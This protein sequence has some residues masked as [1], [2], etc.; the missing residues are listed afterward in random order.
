[1]KL[2]HRTDE[3]RRARCREQGI[4]PEQ[5][6]CLD[7]AWFISKPIEWP[8][9]GENAPVMWISSFDE[10]LIN[11]PMGGNSTVRIRFC[12]WCGKRLPESKQQLWHQTL[13][14]LGYKDPGNEEIPPEFDTDRW[15]RD[16]CP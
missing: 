12:P 1:M 16:R 8:S 2:S 13:G 6:C 11:I 3:E 15:W 14:E 7:M 4:V 9:Q 10:Y 5:H